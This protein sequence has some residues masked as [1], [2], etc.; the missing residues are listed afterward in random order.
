M[1][2][3]ESWGLLDVGRRGAPAMG[4]AEGGQPERAAAET[5]AQSL[6]GGGV[7]QGTAVRTSAALVT[8]GGW[9]PAAVVASALPSANIAGSA[10]SVVGSVL[11]F[12]GSG[13]YGVDQALV[14][15]LA[16]RAGQRSSVGAWASVAAGAK[17][18]AGKL[19]GSGHR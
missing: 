13:S 19:A 8:R 1:D 2:R 5:V 7:G 11:S 9:A 6:H 3:L 15:G 10:M 14:L 18:E 12:Q 16:P 17:H 4:R